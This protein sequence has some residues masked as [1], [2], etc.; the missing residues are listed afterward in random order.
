MTNHIVRLYTLAATVAIFFVA[1]AV[2][3]AHPWSS[4]TATNDPRLVQLAVREQK[5][6]REAVAVQRVVKHRWAVYSEQ[7]AQ[8]Q[9]QNAAIRKQAQLFA[10]QVAAAPQVQVVTLPAVTPTRTS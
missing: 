9:K 6:R 2:I 7:L 10:A 3:A 4:T 1:W 8:R 5:L